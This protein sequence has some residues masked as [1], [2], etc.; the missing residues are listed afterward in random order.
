[1][2]N[3]PI[4]ANVAHQ[5]VDS[6]SHLHMSDVECRGETIYFAVVD[7]FNDGNKGHPGKQTNLDDPTHTDWKKYWGGDLQGVLDKVDYLS[8][9]SP[10]FGLRRFL[11]RS[12][13]KRA[14]PPRSTV[15]GPRTSSA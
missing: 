8:W 13:A 3:R 9:A 7:R 6:T 4:P 10:L 11:S 2:A 15:T 14:G 5:P 12:R 1:M